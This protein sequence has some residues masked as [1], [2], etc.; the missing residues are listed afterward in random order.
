MAAR[1]ISSGTISFGL[2]SIPVKLYSASKSKSVS[3]NMLHSNDKARIKQQLV[4]SGCGE[5][6]D[7]G[8]TLKGYEHAKGQYVVIEAEEL[9]SLEQKS[10]RTIE[11]EEFIPIEQV[12]P[13]YFDRSN[14]LGPD[15]GGSKAYR[16]LRDALVETG[17]VAIGR[18]AT[19][20][21]RQLVLLRA[22]DDGLMMHGLLY[23]D[24]VRTID[25]IDL[26][27][28]VALKAGELKLA[29]QL[30]E[31]LANDRFQPEQ[32]RDDYRDAVLELVDRKVAGEE[33]IAV[34]APEAPA[35]IIDLVEALKKSLE[36]KQGKVAKAGPAKV[37]AKKA[38]AKR[39]RAS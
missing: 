23:S 10:D 19:R 4:C 1:A 12:D 38:A 20:G 28:E 5:V 35:P 15:K 7:R 39:K 2:V 29:T 14:W 3:F 27:D 22:V 32:Y 37:R 6:V 11:I 13:H 21:K 36:A 30:I 31:Q 16:L 33:V 8:D 24:E 17:K 9:Q 25:D 26:G 18:F 34:A